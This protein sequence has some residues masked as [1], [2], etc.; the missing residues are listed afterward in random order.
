MLTSR[1]KVGYLPSNIHNNKEQRFKFST[2]K[3]NPATQYIILRKLFKY[4]RV[5]G[6]KR[7]KEVMSMGLE[8]YLLQ[9][10][11]LYKLS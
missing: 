6:D 7:F 3:H 4:G 9:L 5:T 8:C 1:R 11:D 10:Q 2:F